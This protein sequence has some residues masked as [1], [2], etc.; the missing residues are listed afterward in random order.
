MERTERIA[1]VGGGMI[2]IAAALELTRRGSYEVHV[3]EKDPQPGGLSTSYSWNGIRWDRFYHVVLSTDRELLEFLDELD[4]SDQL[5][6][7][8][9]RSGFYGDGSL[10]SF[11]G[12]ADFARFP[13]L[14]P[15]Q[16]IRLVLGILRSTMIRDATKLDRVYVREWITRLFGRRVFERIWDPLLRSK[17]GDARERTSASFLWATINRLYGARRGSDKREKMGHVH[18]GYGRIL[19]RAVQRLSERGVRIHTG[20]PVVAVRSEYGGG[21]SVTTAS[22]SER[23]DRVILTVPTTELSRIVHAEADEYWSM[24]GS[25]E[26]LGIICVLLILKRPLS[27]YYVINLLDKRLP[28]TGIIEATNI[29]DPHEVESTHLVYLP[30]YMTQNDELWDESDTEI[31][32]RFFEGVRQVFPDVSESDLL[33]QAVF[34][35]RSVQPLQE[36][37]SLER[38]VGIR[39]PV[40]GMYVAN[41]SMIRNSTLNNNAV[42]RLA[43]S[44]VEEMRQDEEGESERPARSDS[45]V[46]R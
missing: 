28:F 6:W 24:L 9:T 2:G 37:G 40:N 41:T 17:L 5:F 3:F 20:E 1:I 21:C 23:F 30:K 15:W 29:V 19:D 34:R 35:E 4:L 7:R 36:V 14:S 32:R 44:V 22:G 25:T 39:T 10:V 43:R 26:Y 16:K 33:H 11:S 42:V 18:G 46:A 31:S 27:P 12:L 45:K 13:F 8:E 38:V